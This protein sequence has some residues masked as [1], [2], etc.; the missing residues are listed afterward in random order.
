MTQ[1]LKGKVAEPVY[2]LLKENKLYIEA[3]RRISDLREHGMYEFRLG[4][5]IVQIT[6]NFSQDKLNIVILSGKE[7]ARLVEN[8][9]S[10][11][12]PDIVDG[13]NY[14]GY[15]VRDIF[16]LGG[17][18]AIG[19]MPVNTCEFPEEGKGKIV[20]FMLD[21]YLEEIEISAEPDKNPADYEPLSEELLSRKSWAA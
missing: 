8:E 20:K 11:I 15:R 12:D 9:L 17:G 2:E 18:V 5:L 4:G 14:V 3:M 19:N 1:M 13:R 16:N 10:A 6:A 21:V 7:N